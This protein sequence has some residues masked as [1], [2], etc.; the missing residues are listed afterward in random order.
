MAKIR[1]A[2]EKLRD[3]TAFLRDFEVLSEIIPVVGTSINQFIA[4][5]DRTIADLFDFTGERCCNVQK[6]LCFTYWGPFALNTLLSL[7]HLEDWAKT[8]VGTPTYS[9]SRSWLQLK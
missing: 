5:A 7:L 2:A 3:A 9:V 8:L 6:L 1:W 4:G